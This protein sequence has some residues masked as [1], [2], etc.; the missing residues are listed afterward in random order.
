MCR[1]RR[2]DDGGGD[3]TAAACETGCSAELLFAVRIVQHADLLRA[4]VGAGAVGVGDHGGV[5][6][7]DGAVAGELF[8]AQ[9]VDVQHRGSADCVQ[10]CDDIR[11]CAAAAAGRGVRG[12]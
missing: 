9:G 10:L 1:L 2:R 11:D 7:V 3:G 8:A 5:D 12:R 6:F 4:A